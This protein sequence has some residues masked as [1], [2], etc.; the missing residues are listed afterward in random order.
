MDAERI[1]VADQRREEEEV[2]FILGALPSIW[3][4]TQNVL[5][6]LGYQRAPEQQEGV[7]LRRTGS[8]GSDA[9][10]DQFTKEAD[11]NGASA[12]AGE[13]LN[14]TDEKVCRMCFCS[15]D[16]LGDD[17]L[18]IG[19]LIAPCHCD[20][21][22]RY[23]HDTCLDQW[24]RKSAATEAARVC[25]QC[26]ARYRFRRRPYANL[27]AFVQASQMLR[28]LACVLI[29]FLLSV[30]LG[31]LTYGTL[32]T[33]ASLEATPLS[34]IRDAALKRVKL[35]NQPWNITL[36]QDKAR[37]DIWIP[38]SA[39]QREGNGA[40]PRI[41]HM[42]Y[43]KADLE[44][45]A[46][47][48][49]IMIQNPVYWK[50]VKRPISKYR[51]N[52]TDTQ[53]VRAKLKSGE[54]VTEEL[55]RLSLGL[56][57]FPLDQWNRAPAQARA[58]Q[59]VSTPAPSIKTVLQ[60]PYSLTPS[61]RERLIGSDL[62]L[63]FS[64][65]FLSSKHGDTDAPIEED[66]VEVWQRQNMTISWEYE[67]SPADLFPNPSEHYLV[68]NLPEWLSYVRYVP[69]A[70]VLAMMD[71]VAFVASVFR[72]WWSSIARSALQLALLLLGSHKELLWCA[73]KAAAAALIAYIDVEYEPVRWNPDNAVVIGP[74]RTRRR[75][76]AAVARELL[77]G[78][79]DNVFG[80]LWLNWWGGY[81]LSVYM[82]PR[83][84][85][86]TERVEM[87]QLA[88]VFAPAFTLLIDV[89]FGG[90][91][92]FSKRAASFQKN[93]TTK[94]TQ[95]DWVHNDLSASE[96]YRRMLASLLGD[97]DASKASL[98]DL[99]L[100]TDQ[101]HL[102]PG[103]VKPHQMAV[104]P[105]LNTWKTVMLLGCLTTTALALVV[106]TKL[107]W[108]STISHFAKQAWLSV[109]SIFR[110]LMHSG[111]AFRHMWRQTRDTSLF[112]V[113]YVVRK[114]KAYAGHFLRSVTRSNAQDA[115]SAFQETATSHIVSGHTGDAADSAE[116]AP[117]PP[118]PQ[119]PEAVPEAILND[120]FM[121]GNHAGIFG[122]ILG[123]LASI[124]GC[125]HAFVFTMRFVL[126]YLP[127]E[128]FMIVYA[129]LQKLI[130]VDVANTEVLDR[131]DVEA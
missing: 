71:R 54:D 104:M 33:I 115:A 2:E 93:H 73:S 89:A 96:G 85:M 111:T 102:L 81:S 128:P 37:A 86:T 68:R 35:E 62:K 24:R 56:P 46:Q 55:E 106:A 31:V 90:L 92:T 8:N 30:V 18:S 120:P 121:Q 119:Q 36:Y 103:R 14:Q 75:K 84:F 61:L 49:R 64:F 53:I 10:H 26:H 28:V 22:M 15:E 131:E 42:I 57:L 100:E 97:K 44:V 20:G 1:H 127:F 114:T 113:R 39:W 29:I 130:Q 78:I 63:S 32:R 5:R 105:R 122:A 19:R 60:T 9:E 110:L 108:D 12:P 23:V 109:V 82:G 41:D 88:A 112:V 67:E 21:S 59:Q 25:G 80:P 11:H 98:Y 43:E 27:M 17:G 99:W 70:F 83:Q 3:N 74:P 58:D 52:Y 7:R 124:Y 4:N 72:P 101:S 76:A 38:A 94:W 34:F 16:E 77:V 129:G 125:T 69:Y 66:E 107:A 48:R 79:A 117:V 13:P 65:P 116:D 123:H 95:A 87:T 6:D 40:V 91:A 118:Q 45:F 47:I 51:S 50:R 126:V